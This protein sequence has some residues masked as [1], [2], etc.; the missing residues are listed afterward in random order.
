MQTHAPWPA[1]P[2]TGDRHHAAGRG[3]ATPGPQ[4]SRA[5]IEP[6]DELPVGLGDVIDDRVAEMVDELLGQRGALRPG[7]WPRLALAGLTLFLAAVMS[8]LLAHNVIAVCL[9]WPS[10]AAIYLAAIRTE[11]S[12]SLRGAGRPGRP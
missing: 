1:E 12:R 5:P 6:A 7:P 4:S 9:V 8:V 3:L 2:I 11:A 10:T